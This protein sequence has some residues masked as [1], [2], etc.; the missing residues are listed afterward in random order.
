MN[1]FNLIQNEFFK[2]AAKQP[3]EKKS[4]SKNDKT[5]SKFFESMGHIEVPNPDPKRKRDKIKVTSLRGSAADTP[6]GKLLREIYNKWKGSGSS[7]VKDHVKSLHTKRDLQKQKDEIKSL[8]QQLKD[9]KEKTE[10]KQKIKEKIES[11]K[12]TIIQ[13]NEK[14]DH[15]NVVIT[16]KLNDQ[17]NEALTTAKTNASKLH[18]SV[19][20][21]GD[22]PKPSASQDI[23]LSNTANNINDSLNKLG[24][25]AS[26][27]D[28]TA[29]PVFSTYHVKFDVKDMKKIQNS[30]EEIGFILGKPVNVR[31]NREK[32]TADIEMQNDT[33]SSVMMKELVTSNKFVNKA[34]NP[35]TM[36]IILGKDKD[37]E[38]EIVDLSDSMTPHALIVGQTGAGK[39]VLLHQII[40]SVLYG[41][42]KKE[43]QLIL[44]D[45]KGGA[46][47]GGYDGSENLAEPVAKNPKSSLAAIARLHKDM[48][49][50]YKLF[51][52]VGVSNINDFNELVT[53]NP[54]NLSES[55]RLSLANLND[56][57]KKPIPKKVLIA[58]ELSD[59]MSN[60]DTRREMIN[61]INALGRKARASGIHMVLATQF[62]SKRVIPTEIQ[63]NLP[64]KTIMKMDSSDGAKYVETPGAENLLGKGDMIVKAPGGD[65][66]VQSGFIKDTKAIAS[67][68]GGTGKEK[69]VEQSKK[70]ELEEKS[71]QKIE[72]SI[73][74][75]QESDSDSDLTN[76]F[77]SSL[78][79]L[80]KK[81]D[82]QK[83]KIEQVL[84]DA[85]QRQN[86][87]QKRLKET[88][89]LEDDESES[90]VQNEALQSK[91][92]SPDFEKS[93]EIEKELEPKV[94]T[95][96]EMLVSPKGEIIEPEV[97]IDT[98]NVNLPKENDDFTKSDLQNEIDEL[99][100]TVPV[101][102][103]NK[104]EEIQAKKNNLLEKLKKV[105]NRKK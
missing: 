83:V 50:R 5:W 38:P 22:I 39:S 26:I 57:E 13:P 47:F 73:E 14:S 51:G 100:K 43:A 90:E 86:D 15:E 34:A 12:K 45:P 33:R 72:N 91:R 16:N 1:H 53:K 82:D 92:Q 28:V 95:N 69:Q 103:I 36:P 71:Q 94:D 52:K 8:K 99:T 2:L 81:L 63:A 56:S 25:K 79:K 77:Q 55:E 88:Q 75:D 97:N 3:T 30:G 64:L 18:G 102:D 21:L 89:Q 46:E 87:I 62:P 93:K 84:A 24:I 105:F 59:L 35:K 96:K 11:K 98:P 61:H 70:N 41:K 27:S 80:R 54:D 49:N 7:A 66:R 104:S 101:N 85:K 9:K 58:D 29:G 42:D 37:G 65:K 48:E 6:K 67:E 23:E 68:F 31:I 32:H 78:S 17:Y 76:A 4:P 40:S 44:L 60:D 20:I 74:L 19:D 10:S